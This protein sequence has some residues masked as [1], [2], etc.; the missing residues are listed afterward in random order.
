MFSTIKK[1]S[2]SFAVFN[3][4][5]IQSLM[6]DMMF[7]YS[8]AILPSIISS[9][10]NDIVGSWYIGD[11]SQENDIVNITF[12]SNGTYVMLQDGDS[13]PV[14]G[15]DSGQDGMERGTYNWNPTTGE[16]HSTA[17]VDTNGEW[18]FSD[19]SDNDTITI[20]N[21]TLI[22]TVPDEGV[23]TLNRVEN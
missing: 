15:D 4:L 18:G 3:L 17:I 10:N 5:M 7:Y 11:A 16:F 2:L 12:F 6:A 22:L 9:Q 21:N 19:L 14:T 23:F 8:A 13:D 20:E 1:L